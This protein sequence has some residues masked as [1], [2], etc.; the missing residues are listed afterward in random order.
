MEDSSFSKSKRSDNTIPVPQISA[1]FVYKRFIIFF[2]S[3]SLFG[4]FFFVGCEK[5]LN[6]TGSSFFLT[7]YFLG[8][9]GYLFL[10]FELCGFLLLQISGTFSDFYRSYPKYFNLTNL[11]IGI[12]ISVIFFSYCF[13]GSASLPILFGLIILGI[14]AAVKKY[15]GEHRKQL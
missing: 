10:F 14:C 12:I 9:L 4:L 11:G 5:F 13:G 3:T 1:E 15:H 2:L 6:S 7:L 8:V